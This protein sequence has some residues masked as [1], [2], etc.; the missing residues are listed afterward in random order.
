MNNES[1][2]IAVIPGRERMI[3]STSVELTDGL[4]TTSPTLARSKYRSNASE[5]RCAEPSASIV[6]VV[7]TSTTNSSGSTASHR[8]RSQRTVNQAEP[9]HTLVRTVAVTALTLR[10]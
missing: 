2:V 6:P 1:V 3:E 4:T 10:R 7:P 5:V 9:L 8:R